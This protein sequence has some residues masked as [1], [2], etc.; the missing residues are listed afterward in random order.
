MFEEFVQTH[1]RKYAAGEKE[2]R[3]EIFQSNMK[4]IEAS[5]AKNLSYTLGVTPF[6]D[7]TFEE[8]RAQ[9]VGGVTPFTAEQKKSML[10]FEKPE[11]FT[12]PDSIDWVSQG[13]VS[14]VKNQGTCGSCWTFS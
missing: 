14:S 7:L 5:N 4:M 10:K 9:F 6:T 2:R 1:G 8:F 13:A 3:F 11:G 12:V